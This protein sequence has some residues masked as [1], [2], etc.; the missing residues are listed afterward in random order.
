MQGEAMTL[1]GLQDH[2]W[3]RLGPR[4]LIAGRKAVAD[5][6]QLAVENW[7]AEVLTSCRD[8]EQRQIVAAE[9]VRS[10]KRVHMAVSPEDNKTMAVLWLFLL[11]AV[12]SAVVNLIMKW[13]LESASNRV[14]LVCWRKELTA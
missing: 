1:D 8:D 12:A 5:L 3:R 14:F 4:K 10:M 2:V 9:V 6:V 13:W 11:Q 7:P